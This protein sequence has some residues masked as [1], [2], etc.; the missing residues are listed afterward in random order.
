M[1]EVQPL[2]CILIST[3]GSPSK[4]SLPLVP[5]CQH[6][7]AVACRH[8]GQAGRPPPARANAELHSASHFGSL[9]G[10]ATVCVEKCPTRQ[11]QILPY[12]PLR[13]SP[14]RGET[15][16]SGLLLGEPGWHASTARV[17]GL[18]VGLLSCF[19]DDICRGSRPIRRQ[20]EAE[21]DRVELLVACMP[22]A[23]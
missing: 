12:H 7:S 14:V 18:L 20:A 19:Q 8:G 10:V 16:Q 1:T 11:Y 17:A 13:R 6:C 3:T 4:F 15:R 21:S 22:D 23:R 9:E 5:C 2:I